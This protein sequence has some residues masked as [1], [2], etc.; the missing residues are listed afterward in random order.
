MNK[1][2]DNVNMQKAAVS[3]VAAAQAAQ[4]LAESAAKD[5]SQVTAGLASLWAALQKEASKD[6]GTV[7]DVKP[8]VGEKEVFAPPKKVE[9]ISDAFSRMSSKELKIELARLGVASGDFFEKSEILTAVRSAVAAAAVAKAA[10]TAKVSD[11]S[12]KMQ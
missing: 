4:R 7:V 10:A 12:E 6:L 5:P 9:P 8:A 2:A 11:K 3:A 1:L